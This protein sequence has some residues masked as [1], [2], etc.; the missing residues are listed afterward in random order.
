M[1]VNKSTKM[2]EINNIEDIPTFRHSEV[3]PKRQ[4]SGRLTVW[5]MNSSTV[6][7]Q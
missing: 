2:Q 5:A 4:N 6:W 3:K 1:P 7:S